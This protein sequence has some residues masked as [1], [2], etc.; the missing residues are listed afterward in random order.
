MQRRHQR[1]LDKIRH[2][3]VLGTIPWTDIEKLLQ[4]LG[5]EIEEREGSRVAVIWNGEVQVFHRPH[6]EKE[7]DKGAVASVKAFI[8]RHYR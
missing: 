5:A 2:R 8:N 3:P 4:A 6:P 1:T 7:T